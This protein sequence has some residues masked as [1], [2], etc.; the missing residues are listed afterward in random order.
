MSSQ[1]HRGAK[2]PSQPG[3]LSE[4]VANLTHMSIDAA[5]ELS[6]YDKQTC[7]L[8]IR[9]LTTY[10]NNPTGPPRPIAQVLGQLTLL[11]EQRAKLQ[12]TEHAEE[13]RAMQAV[14]RAEQEATSH[15]QAT[16]SHLQKEIDEAQREQDQT[17]Q[18]CEAL[19]AQVKLQEEK[20]VIDTGDS[21]SGLANPELFPESGIDVS[22]SGSN[23]TETLGDQLRAQ[24]RDPRAEEVLLWQTQHAQQRSH[25]VNVTPRGEPEETPRST[26]TWDYQANPERTVTGDY[27]STPRSAVTGDYQAG[28]RRMVTWDYQTT[29]GTRRADA[30]DGLQP[31]IPP[32]VRNQP[33]PHQDD[34]RTPPWR[35]DGYSQPARNPAYVGTPST[36]Q[37]DARYGSRPHPGWSSNPG[38]GRDDPYRGE[39]ESDNSDSSAAPWRDGIRTRQL[40]SLAKDIDRF[41]PDV[42]G[43]NVDDYLR[44]VERCLLDLA[45]PSSREKL[46]LIW[47]TTA[48]NVHAF[49]ETLSPGIRDRYSALCQALREEYSLFTDQ[50]SATLGA[51]AV[52]QR[53]NEPPREYYRR[54]RTAYF[55][56]RNAPGLEEETAFRSLFLHN[57]HESVRY[58]V[59]MHCRAG[60]L[61]M[62]EMRRYSQLAWETRTRPGRGP[63]QDARV[64][65]IQAQPN[66]DLALE[67]NEIPHA[68]INP[69]RQD[70]E[71]RPDQQSIRG[72]RGNAGSNQLRN[73]TP[74]YLNTSQPRGRDWSEQEPHQ[75]QEKGYGDKHPKQGRQPERGRGQEHWNQPEHWRR[76]E[77]WNQPE[78]WRKPEHWNQ[79]EH[80][81]KQ[82][83]W[84]PQEPHQRMHPRMED[85]IRRCVAEAVRDL[86]IPTRPPAPPGSPKNPDKGPPST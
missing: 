21:R 73:Q 69:R 3:D 71:R 11:Y 2:A 26:V 33:A 52:V 81:R 47:K 49:M 75:R 17:L 7:D 64:L 9:E 42:R 39:P 67:G 82:E 86:E 80:G 31:E 85:V 29:P 16:N 56:G 55:Q 34:G 27:Q 84:N 76:Q 53:K 61:T 15:L 79:H 4:L 36:A 58:D 18:E 57:L 50:A 5:N 40:E 77:H 46:K 66:V 12:V 59:T 8:K 70:R 41:D 74:R 45:S 10:L 25:P 78:Q 30:D 68:K 1:D 23:G 62:Q 14:C 51:F 54:L 65:G 32:P 37:A 43:S 60:N 63:E 72:N 6:S 13:L 20:E 83:P 28:P 24:L 19:R 35:A 44:E 48:R 22:P 38:A